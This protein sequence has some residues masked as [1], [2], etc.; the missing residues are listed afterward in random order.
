[1]TTEQKAANAITQTPKEVTICGTAY[2]V[3]PATFATLIEVGAIAST[4]PKTL[5][6]SDGTAIAFMLHSAKEV[7]KVAGIIATLVVGVEPQKAKRTLIPKWVQNRLQTKNRRRIEEL[8][9]QLQRK[10][11]PATA[12]EAITELLPLLEIEH[13]FGLTTFLNQMNLMPAGEVVETTPGE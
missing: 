9:H 7:S 6:G 4:L 8:T 10:L 11:T 13:F 5:Q 12:Y 3:K 1:M 2:Q